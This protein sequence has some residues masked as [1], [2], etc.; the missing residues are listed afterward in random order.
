MKNVSQVGQTLT[1]PRNEYLFQLHTHTCSDSGQISGATSLARPLPRYRVWMTPCDITAPA[2]NVPFH[3]RVF[4]EA[5][6]YA[7]SARYPPNYKA[8]SIQILVPGFKGSG[9][10]GHG[11]MVPS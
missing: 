5:A 11:S 6:V 9:S 4:G 2:T 8:T 3:F 10:K 7:D 1:A